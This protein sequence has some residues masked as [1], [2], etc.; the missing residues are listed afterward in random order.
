MRIITQNFVAAGKPYYIRANAGVLYL[1]ITDGKRY[2][3]KTIPYG[4]SWVEIENEQV[5]IPATGGGTVTSV[6]LSVAAIGP[7]A[8]S[9]S[10]SPITTN[11]TLQ[12]TLAGNASQYIRGDGSLATFPVVV[13][14]VTSVGLTVPSPA[15]PAFSVTGS[16]VTGAGTL[17]IGANGASTDYV[18]GDGSLAAFPAIPSTYVSTFSAGSTGLLP[19]SATSGAVVLS[20]TLGVANGGTG[21]TT[22]TGALIGNGTGAFTAVTGT[23][24]QLLRRNIA[25]TAY[26]F[27]TPGYLTAAITS[28]NGLT[29]AVQ[30]FVNDTNVTIVSAGSTHTLTWSG[31]LPI[32]RGGTGVSTVPANGQLLIGNGTGYTVA[33]LTASTG[34][35]I[36]NGAG[37]ISIT[38]SDRG[39]S[40]NIFKNIASPLQSTIVADNN[41]DTLTIIGGTGISISTNAGTDELT[42]TNT[43]PGATYTGRIG[44]VNI[45]GNN[46]ISTVATFSGFLLMGG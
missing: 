9:V 1:D 32:S 4:Q 27:F 45:D 40:Q 11:G 25:D 37:S 42:I 31:L 24:G 14:T 46:E 7:S 19:S 22:L 26:E 5:Y 17:A 18:R 44:D 2:R 23:S 33:T 10:G 30:T 29:V 15:N 20:G 16:P 28:L 6:G 41:N 39:S 36:A 34:I 3:Q 43:Q 38:N 12:I 35:S 21:A 13:G 8:F